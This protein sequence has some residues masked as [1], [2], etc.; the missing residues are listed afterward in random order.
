[1]P[2]G[3]SALLQAW[4]HTGR[5]AG[6]SLVL[7]DG[8]VDLIGIQ[9]LGAAPRWKLSSLIDRA[10]RIEGS[11]GQRYAGY[12]LQPGARIHAAKLLQAVEG[13][14]LD[15]TPRVL[16]RLDA[17]TGLD[18]RIQEALQALSTEACLKQAQRQLGVSER[19]LQRV[20]SAATGRPPL[21]WKRLSRLRRAAREL[22]GLLP[23]AH[24]AADHGYADQA[25]M[26]LEFRHWLG[27]SPAQVR[28]RSDVLRL[29]G[30]PGYG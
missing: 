8:C 5:E 29:L 18:A 21:Y 16:E 25:H 27:L 6:G 22:S 10:C 20:I 30:E 9:A 19:S 14:E 11:A 3:A 17:T 24:I 13:L 23:L 15:D 2:T 7:P 4:R 26:N 28:H 12:R 1:M